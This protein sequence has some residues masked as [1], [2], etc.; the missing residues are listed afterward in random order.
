MVWANMLLNNTSLNMAAIK[1]SYIK[2]VLVPSI[3]RNTT[4]KILLKFKFLIEALFLSAVS[5]SYG[6]V[7]LSKFVDWIK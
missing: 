5:R 4:L 1:H 7:K 3:Y 2:F 6:K